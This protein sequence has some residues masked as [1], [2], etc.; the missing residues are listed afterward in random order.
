MTRKTLRR[1]GFILAGALA[2]A[3]CGV[4]EAEPQKNDHI[5]MPESNN[6]GESGSRLFAGQPGSVAY[7]G[8]F[9]IWSP[10]VNSKAIR[11][12]NEKSTAGRV[13]KAR[14]VE[15][16]R[17]EHQVEAQEKKLEAKKQ[18]LQDH[19]LAA[20]KESPEALRPVLA[21]WFS[22]K[23]AG[24]QEQGLSSSDA[25]TVR[26]RFAAYCDY[27]VWELAVSQ[28]AHERYVQRP[29]P[30]Q[31]CEPY[32]EDQGY[33]QGD[34][35]LCMP[36]DSGEGKVYFQCLWRRGV[37]KT[38]VFRARASAGATCQGNSKTR[39]KQIQEWLSASRG[40]PS[41]LRRI[42]AND[43]KTGQ[44]RVGRRI[45]EEI[46]GSDVILAALELGTDAQEKLL[47]CIDAFAPAGKSF[48][49]P[50][51]LPPWSTRSLKQLKDVV[52]APYS[53][54]VEGASLLPDGAAGSKKLKSWYSV[55]TQPLYE[56]SY[57]ASVERDGASPNDQLFNRPVDAPLT[58]ESSGLGSILSDKT[59]LESDALKA[60]SSQKL[61][62]LSRGIAK[63]ETQ[64]AGLARKKEKARKALEQLRGRLRALQKDN[65]EATTDPETALLTQSF[66]LRI[67][68][69]ADGTRWRVE[70]ELNGQQFTGCLDVA[71]SRRLEK[72]CSASGHPAAQLSYDPE[73]RELRIGV[74][75]ENAKKLGLARE[76]A[77]GFSQLRAKSL[78]GKTVEFSLYPN[79]LQG[80][81]EFFTGTVRIKQGHETVYQGSASGDNFRAWKDRLDE[82][83]AE[84]AAAP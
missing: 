61:K 16:A 8:S 52:S 62:R 83:D 76:A 39:T 66:K 42:L 3:A 29:T 40:K 20:L 35:D 44:G 37:V 47:P 19:A 6:G 78:R 23:L 77:S 60:G 18:T 26:S 41:F 69:K 2:L 71:E 33:F 34:G 75:V 63:I 65:V 7:Q 4:E 49:P 79:R 81:L 9:V 72:N 55:L 15:P 80:T 21:Q 53:S 14:L 58:G 45:A 31:A 22:G 48:E 1:R 84:A 43:K 27:K 46:L 82:K 56:F 54:R 11:N 5:E 32:Y 59:I 67:G 50:E 74:P 57:R 17:I 30:L 24:L 73:L 12:V 36:S 13:V 64:K 28:L 10:S 25:Q 70:F 38:A 51:D 68:T